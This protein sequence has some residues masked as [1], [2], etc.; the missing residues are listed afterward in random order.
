MKARAQRSEKNASQ[1][2]SFLASQSGLLQRKCACGGAPGVDGECVECRN[3]RL[4]RNTIDHAESSTVL[5]IVQDLSRPPGQ[6]L[7]A[8]ARAFVNPTFGHDFSRIS[9][10]SNA[11]PTIQPKLTTSVPGDGG[12][13]EAARVAQKVMRRP[14]HEAAPPTKGAPEQP[15]IGRGQASGAQGTPV[16]P[17]VHEVLRS[18]GQHLDARS[19]TF[20]ESGFGWSFS[21]VQVHTDGKAAESARAMN[22]QAYT[23]GQ[24]LVF[25]A[26][27]YAPNTRTGRRLLAH[28]LAHVVQQA[29]GGMSATSPM[30]DSALESAAD[31]TASAISQG[32]ERVAVTGASA[33]GLARQSTLR[34]PARNPSILS[35]EELE[36]EIDLIRQ[37]LLDNPVS[38]LE[39]DQL[40][41]ELEV[42][43]NEAIRRNSSAPEAGPV[44]QPTGEATFSGD[45]EALLAGAANIVEFRSLVG[46][47]EAI[48]SSG[49]LSAEEVAEVNEAISRA[50]TALLRRFA[51]RREAPRVQYAGAAV[52]LTGFGVRTA[53]S[54]A[55]GAAAG[56]SIAATA[57]IG[58][59]VLLGVWYLRERAVRE[60]AAHEDEQ[61]GEAA[62]EAVTEAVNVIG[63]ILLAATV[64]EQVRSLSNQIVIHLARILGTTVGGQP[65]DHQ[66][67]P[68]PDQ[69]PHWWKELKN[70]LRQIR[71]KGLTPKQLLRE[72]RKRFSPEQLAEIRDA[73]RRAAKRM[74]EDPP[75]FP[76]VGP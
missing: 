59:F 32:S 49:T 27:Q 69:R 76:P 26:G 43:E 28:E 1:D 72:L 21:Q 2:C 53:A 45:A 57:G 6:P 54:A 73:L 40:M 55:A 63:Q 47:Y 4:R 42:L 56:A 52:A 66:E 37:W 67:D 39:N 71:D 10:Y 12:E 38:S 13:Q 46:H 65:P 41:A 17:I 20:M 24:D 29:R 8:K 34:T 22:A 33:P 15:Q 11:P 70:F 25:G 60:R 61:I 16:P 23:V 5:P 68:N 74:G 48:L 75:D 31:Q 14:D 19:R 62:H 35:N 30:P 18:P 58:L 50:N 36:Q 3:K 44:A 7:D 9:V 51:P 64:G